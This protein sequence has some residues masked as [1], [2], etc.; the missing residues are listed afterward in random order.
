MN[1]EGRESSVPLMTTQIPS[2]GL[3]IELGRQVRK[4]IRQL[5]QGDSTLT[6]QIEAAVTSL[7]ESLG[8]EADVEVVP[9]V[10]LYRLAE[11]D[12]I[13]VTGT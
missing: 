9:V 6:W 4:D 12:Y 5:K 1:M 2:V 11:P 8:I 7:R 13:V 3:F 10:I